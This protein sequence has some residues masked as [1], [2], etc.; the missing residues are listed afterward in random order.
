MPGQVSV[1]MPVKEDRKEDQKDLKDDKE[2]T[3]STSEVSGQH[4]EATKVDENNIKDANKDN[5]ITTSPDK[6]KTLQENQTNQTQIQKPCTESSTE[7]SGK[8]VAVESK[9]DK[10]TSTPAAKDTSG[11]SQGAQGDGTNGFSKEIKKGIYILNQ[12]LDE[13]LESQKS[14]GVDALSSEYATVEEDPIVK[15]ER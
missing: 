7:G 1:Y 10:T 4:E 12:D 15:L 2:K 6:S 3:T 8:T 13:K 11:P 5:I 9:Q 14:Q